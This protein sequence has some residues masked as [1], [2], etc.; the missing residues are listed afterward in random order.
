M[1]WNML[2]SVFSKFAYTG[3]LLLNFFNFNFFFFDMIVVLFFKFHTRWVDDK[4]RVLFLRC[5]FDW[6]PFKEQCMTIICAYH[7]K[8]YS[9]LNIKPCRFLVV[10]SADEKIFKINMSYKTHALIL[11]DIFVSRTQLNHAP[12]V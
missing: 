8:I 5:I 4:I 9:F 10:F 12:L 3:F 2:N 11:F 1:T 7:K 6:K